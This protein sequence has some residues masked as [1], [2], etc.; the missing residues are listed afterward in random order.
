MKE[1]EEVPILLGRPFLSTARAMIDVFNK[2]ISLKVGNEEITY[3][4]E[5]SVNNA[6]FTDDDLEDF[7]EMDFIIDEFVQKSLPQEQL[8]S[9]ISEEGGEPDLPIHLEREGLHETAKGAEL[10]PKL[11][12][13]PS[14]LEYAF[15]DNDP[16]FPVIISSSLSNEEKRL[17]LRE[18]SI[19]K[20]A[21]AW[22]VSDI[23]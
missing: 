7:D 6:S 23:K 9:I 17:L 10:I 4:L 5:R 20:G 1:D 19:H 12:V 15:L 18:L 3:D 21:F 13:L 14:H 22:K 16:E 2:K 11:K 8:H